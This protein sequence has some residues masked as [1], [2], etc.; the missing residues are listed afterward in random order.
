MAMRETAL[1]ACSFVVRR[2]THVFTVYIILGKCL[3]MFV[4]YALL[5]PRDTSCRYVGMTND[6]TERYIAHLRM[7]E[8]NRQKNRWVLELKSLGLV[9]LCRTLETVETERQARERERAW[10][11]GFME[12]DEPLYNSERIGKR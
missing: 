4:I 7:G 1:Q 11:E 9:P 3:N 8:V 12:I 5:D 10:I 6:L 2:K